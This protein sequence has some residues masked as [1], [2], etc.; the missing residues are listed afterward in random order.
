MAE[1]I[2]TSVGEVARDLAEFGRLKNV[3]PVYLFTFTCRQGPSTF[4]KVYKK[5]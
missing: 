2:G 3:S 5:D 1:S 4:G